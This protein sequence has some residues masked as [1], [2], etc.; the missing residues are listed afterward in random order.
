MY[1][2]FY[3]MA[4]TPRPQMPMPHLH[5]LHN[6]QMFLHVLHKPQLALFHKPHLFLGLQKHHLLLPVLHKPQFLLLVH[7]YYRYLLLYLL[8]WMAAVATIIRGGAGNARDNPICEYLLFFVLCR[9]WPL[10]TLYFII[11]C[12]TLYNH[13]YGNTLYVMSSSFLCVS[14]ITKN[15]V[16]IMFCL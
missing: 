11:F 10:H 15:L 7:V 5:L 14:S 16:F 1:S 9:G 8:L 13:M 12:N 6:P 2:G 3:E 4:S